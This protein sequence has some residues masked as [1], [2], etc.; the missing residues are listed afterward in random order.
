MDINTRDAEFCDQF[1]ERPAL[2]F[3]AQPSIRHLFQLLADP[4]RKITIVAGAG[5][6]LDAELPTWSELIR[7]ICNRISEERWRLA[8]HEDGTELLRKAE[9][10]LELAIESRASTADEVIRDSLYEK[11]N[12][13][14]YGR[15]SDSIARL[16]TVLGDRVRFA[17][18]NFDLL[19]EDALRTYTDNGPIRSLTLAELGVADD[20]WGSFDAESAG[21]T[22]RDSVLHLHGVLAPNSPAR[23]EIVL[24]ETSFLRVGPKVRQVIESQLRSS[25]VIF[26]GV[27]LTDPNLVGPL[28]SL[29]E[30][31]Y[32]YDPPYLLTVASPEPKASDRSAS[33][34]YAIKKAEYL[35][36][37]LNVRTIFF[38]SYGQLQQFGYEM[39]LAAWYPREYL[40]DDSPDTSLRYGWRF[41]RT[42]DRAYSAIG[43]RNG[44]HMAEEDAARRLSDRL[45]HEL[46]GSDPPSIG[47]ILASARR[48]LEVSHVAVN[49]KLAREHRDDFD[50]EHFGIFLWLRSRLSDSFAA[51]DLRLTGVSLYTHREEW[52]L[53]RIAHVEGASRHIAARATF[54]GRTELKD[55]EA[56]TEY[57]VWRSALAVPFFLDAGDPALSDED[58]KLD[59]IDIG[60]ITLNSTNFAV[61]TEGSPWKGKR[62]I[63]SIL[64]LKDRKKLELELSRIGTEV[65]SGS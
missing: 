22:S 29:K 11:N 46:K 59:S 51:Y 62:S 63:M 31:G 2:S 57:P 33:R 16:V 52:S 44:Q 38:K 13:P 50:S 61:G 27:S 56:R 36:S 30:S 3:E 28:W 23:G 60:V 9:S 10:S 58:L 32:T 64:S 55:F 47:G 17:T 15:L 4:G 43:C 21:W 65:A 6:S 1:W 20:G 7:N 42:L 24:T 26:V 41:T 53:D 19:L 35:E 48:R 37:K 12:S 14:T 54:Y 39:T 5:V 45:Y 25:V 40:D 49:R 18:T 8:A 34:A